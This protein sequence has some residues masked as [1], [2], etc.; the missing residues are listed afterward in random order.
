MSLKE[1]MEKPV[2]KGKFHAISSFAIKS[3]VEF[4]LIGTVVEGEI[5]TQ[6]FINVPLNMALRL[7]LRIRQIEEV[8]MAGDKTKYLLLTIQDDETWSFLLGLDIGSEFLNSTEE[9]DD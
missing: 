8:E 1:F 2:A 3:R 4:Y 7:T 9:G 6:W 5:R